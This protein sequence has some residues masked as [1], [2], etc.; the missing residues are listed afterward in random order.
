MTENNW[1]FKSITFAG[2]EKI[3]DGLACGGL[4]ISGPYFDEET[5]VTNLWNITHINSGY[6]VV[7]F[8]ADSIGHTIYTANKIL[9]GGDWTFSGIEPPNKAELEE[10][11]KAAIKEAASKFDDFDAEPSTVM[12]NKIEPCALCGRD[13]QPLVGAD[14]EE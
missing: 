7:K 4:F 10:V 5:G 11:V 2:V 9:A 14:R 6:R 3:I 8:E 13:I 1:Q 12:T